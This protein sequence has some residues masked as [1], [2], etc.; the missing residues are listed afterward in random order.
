MRGADGYVATADIRGA[1]KG[2]ETE[3]LDGLS[4]DWRRPK[5]KPHITCP[6]HDHS[7]NNPSWRWDMPKALAF[8][9][10][11]DGSHS[12]FDVV[13]KV[14]EVGFEVA[15]V[16]VAEL[17]DRP[18]LIRE[19]RVRKS[20]KGEGAGPS[21]QPR[22]SATAAGCRLAD[23]AAAK[24]LPSEF[25][26]S[27]GIREISHLGSPAL[28][29]PYFEPHG[30]EP[31]IRFRI[32]LD[33]DDRFRWK[34]GTKPRLYG[35]QKLASARKGGSIT[36]VEGESDCQTL[37]FCGFPALGLPGAGNWN[38]DRDAPLLGDFDVIYTVIEPDEGGR[39]VRVWLSRS[40][41]R[42]DARTYLAWKHQ[43]TQCRGMVSLKVTGA[44][45][46]AQYARRA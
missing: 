5:A 19:R 13:M 14:E 43:L 10:C 8:C 32:A 36:L 4:I 29:I 6:Y 17:L 23:Y 20:R 41:I 28:R 15:K 16:R 24:R 3:V 35:L 44:D 39:R 33:G 11:I 25:L 2:R 30:G 46:C 45:G 1:A 18:D 9:T 21:K 7:D 26:L 42:V 12:I 34:K 31:A 27:L 40:R 22:N 38:D 37:W